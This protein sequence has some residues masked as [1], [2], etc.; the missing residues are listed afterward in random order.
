MDNSSDIKLLMQWDIKPGIDQEYFEFV[1]KELIPGMSNIG[2][3]PIGAWYTIYSRDYQPQI[4]VEG[5]LNN[6]KQVDNLFKSDEWQELH[7]KLL[8]YVENYKQ[9]VFL[10]SGGFQI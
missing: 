9:K 7:E 4:T 10:S 5:M 1:I 2:L 3:E 6:P 8:N